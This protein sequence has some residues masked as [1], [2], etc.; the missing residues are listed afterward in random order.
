M[1]STAG[2][3]LSNEYHRRVISHHDITL[4]TGA[5]ANA[6]ALLSR[7]SIEFGLGWSWRPQRVR[8]SIDDPQT[9]VI[10]AREAGRLTG[11]A[12]MK[13][14]DAEAHLLL[15]AVHAAHR[16]RGVGGALLAWLEATLRV[17][18]IGTVH[19]EA[20]A[21]NTA[22]RAFYRAHGFRETALVPGYYGGVEDSVR[23]QKR[24]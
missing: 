5:D 8:R 10:V 17:A 6:I 11:F 22:G 15:L 19:L 16:R 24:L 12:L 2:G 21:R 20:R 18:G 9:N 14:A 23:M 1:R 7:E 3:A 13:Y 4:A